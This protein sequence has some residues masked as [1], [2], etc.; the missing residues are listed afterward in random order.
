MEEMQ[1]ADNWLKS[2]DE[3]IYKE[4]DSEEKETLCW[5]LSEYAKHIKSNQ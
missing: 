1:K 4:L 5:M 2:F 3:N